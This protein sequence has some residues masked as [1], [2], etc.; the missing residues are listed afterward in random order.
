MADFG[1]YC[2]LS[3]LHVVYLIVIKQTF[4]LFESYLFIIQ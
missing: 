2:I 4:K 1:R 3:D